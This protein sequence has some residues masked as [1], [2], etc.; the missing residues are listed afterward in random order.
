MAGLSAGILP[1]SPVV[2]VLGYHLHGKLQGGF[3]MEVPGVRV[4]GQD[5]KFVE[6]QIFKMMRVKGCQ[7]EAA[8]NLYFSPR[9]GVCH[10][11]SR[12]WDWAA[13]RMYR[14]RLVAASDACGKNHKPLWC[15]APCESINMRCT[16]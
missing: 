9:I 2:A 11:W 13:V 12:L 16:G 10:G 8:G 4:V 15:Y 1:H 3:G 6:E 14:Y 7:L 5:L